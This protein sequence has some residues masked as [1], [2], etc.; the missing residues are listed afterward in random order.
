MINDSCHCD[1]KVFYEVV[2]VP[3][4]PRLYHKTAHKMNMYSFRNVLTH[5]T[6]FSIMLRFCKT[7]CLSCNVMNSAYTQVLR[8]EYI[9]TELENK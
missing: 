6:D 4:H 8:E 5:K 2:A 9:K 7:V 3:L 1:C